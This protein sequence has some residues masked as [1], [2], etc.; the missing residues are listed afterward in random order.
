MREQRFEG[1]GEREMED[2]LRFQNLDPGADLQE[3]ETD[4]VELGAGE[5]CRRQEGG[6]ECMHENVSGAME[7]KAKLI[8]LE[9]VTTGAI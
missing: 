8:G 7:E 6:T 4:G 2:D 3:T 5:L 1:I 9:L